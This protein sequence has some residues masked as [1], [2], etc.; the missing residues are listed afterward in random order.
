M[1]REAYLSGMLTITGCVAL[2]AIVAVGLWVTG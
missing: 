1:Q 2:L